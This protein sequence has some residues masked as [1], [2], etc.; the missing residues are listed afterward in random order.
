MKKISNEDLIF[1]ILSLGLAGYTFIRAAGAAITHDEVGGYLGYS[2]HPVMDILRF[3]N[4]QLGN[5]VLNSLLVK[6]TAYLFGVSEFSLR[7]PNLIGHLL[8]LYFS[9]KIIRMLTKDKFLAIAGFILV[10][11]NPYMLDFFSLSRGYGLEISM[12]VVSIY[13]LMMFRQ[14]GKSA[15]IW[16][17]MIMSALGVLS[18]FTFIPVYF[19]MILLINFLVLVEFVR[20]KKSLKSSLMGMVKVNVPILVISAGLA[21]LVVGPIIRLEAIGEFSARA[22]KEGFWDNMFRS[23]IRHSLYGQFSSDAMQNNLTIVFQALSA[24]LVMLLAWY[25]YK[26]RWE[27]TRSGFFLT[28][29]LL[30]VICL[31]FFLQHIVMGSRYPQQRTALFILPLFLFTLIACLDF[32]AHYKKLVIPLRILTWI[33]TL[34]ILVHFYNSANFRYYFD[35]PNDADTKIM[36]EENLE[37][38]KQSQQGES[39]KVDL[40]TYWLCRPGLIF[41]LDMKKI[42]WIN[43]VNYRESFSGPADY[44]YILREYH[45]SL[46]K[47]NPEKI[48]DYPV[49]RTSLYR[50]KPPDL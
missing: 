2:I 26:D 50:E 14:K 9:W 3:T 4:L 22:N 12:M 20:Q 30:L 39:D 44:Y 7:L 13:L 16:G 15:Y 43:L 24:M 23:V 48:K 31:W 33:V 10:N 47:F 34:F 11:V 17:S 25:I 41:Y 32:V 8:Y 6:L 45:D 38:M 1:I 18:N 29:S 35:W 49:S 5:H 37:S 42:N 21:A 46:Q 19:C 27:A 36:L 28:F 40:G